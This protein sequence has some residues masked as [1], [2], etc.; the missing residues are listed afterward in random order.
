MTY[1]HVTVEQMVKA[2][3][4]ILKPEWGDD[5]DIEWYL[6][7]S[8]NNGID[9]P[10]YQLEREGQVEVPGHMTASGNPEICCVQDIAE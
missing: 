8:S 4:G 1:E 6:S 3:S 9:A 5:R 10:F 2:M 7:G